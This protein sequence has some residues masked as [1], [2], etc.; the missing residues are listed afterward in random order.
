MFVAVWSFD[1]FPT[2]KRKTAHEAIVS[3]SLH[4]LKEQQVTTI[5]HVVA[6][7]AIAADKRHIAFLTFSGVSK[8]P[9]RSPA[10]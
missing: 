4:G 10:I 6:D 7:C 9:V 1:C 3:L 2:R 8:D 5:G